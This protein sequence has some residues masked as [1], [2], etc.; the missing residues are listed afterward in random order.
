M[1]KEKNI[2]MSK[3]AIPKVIQQAMEAE[4]ARVEGRKQEGG[5]Q[6]TLVFRGRVES[7]R[8]QLAT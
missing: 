3:Q 7:T 5:I 4:K 2:P 1:C 8:N 6:L